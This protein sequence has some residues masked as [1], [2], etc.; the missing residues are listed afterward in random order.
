MGADRLS[1]GSGPDTLSGGT[2][3]VE[4][5]NGAIVTRRDT[6]GICK[7]REVRDVAHDTVHYDDRRAPLRISLDGVANDGAAGEGDNVLDDVEV[8]HGGRRGDTL[9]GNARRNFL[10][11][12]PGSDTLVGGGGPDVLEGAIEDHGTRSGTR[13]NRLLGGAGGDCL[14][15]G[16]GGD[17]L[18]GS[19][20]ADTLSGEG[21]RDSLRA[22]AGRDYVFAR[23]LTRDLVDGGADADRAT[24]DRRDRVA[25]VER[26]VAPPPPPDGSILRAR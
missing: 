4:E 12:G 24:I 18:R 21:G 23:D 14:L 6:I 20:G 13:P 16:G 10:Q 2:L 9:I 8:V 11:G 22:G 1:G 25:R 5:L 19:D 3:A 26:L 17:S 7:V 15:G